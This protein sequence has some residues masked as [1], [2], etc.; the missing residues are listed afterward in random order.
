MAIRVSVWLRSNGWIPGPVC[1]SAQAGRLVG[2]YH[3]SWS[4]PE[5]NHPACQPCS[6]SSTLLDSTVTQ[7]LT[8]Q[9]VTRE[10]LQRMC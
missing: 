5:S 4:I 8:R 2:A 9:V 1:G 7:G 10:T 6:P 3:R